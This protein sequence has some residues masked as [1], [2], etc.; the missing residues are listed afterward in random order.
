[1]SPHILVTTKH[2][3]EITAQDGTASYTTIS[4]ANLNSNQTLKVL[5]GIT[6]DVQNQK[7]SRKM[8]TVKFI[9]EVGYQ[10]YL[11]PRQL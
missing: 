4:L 1:M 11:M 2:P 7:I 10:R 3:K 5:S 9:G 8:S 6:Y